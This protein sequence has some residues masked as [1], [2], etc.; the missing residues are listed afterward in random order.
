MKLPLHE[1]LFVKATAPS[2]W[3]WKIYP[4]TLP[5][6][7]PATKNFWQHIKTTNIGNKLNTD[8]AKTY[9]HCVN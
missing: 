1:F 5:V 3:S 4:L 7:K 8:S 9:P 2:Y 6:V